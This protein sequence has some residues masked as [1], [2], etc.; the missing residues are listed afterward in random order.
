MPVIDTH[1]DHIHTTCKKH[2]YETILAWMRWRKF[3]TTR[4]FPHSAKISLPCRS[5]LAGQVAAILP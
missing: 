5:P 4:A 2:S 3:V 1:G